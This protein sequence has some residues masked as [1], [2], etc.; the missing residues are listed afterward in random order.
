MRVEIEFGTDGRAVV[1]AIDLTGDAW[2]DYLHYLAETQ[3]AEAASNRRTKNRALR[4]ALA[5][6]F[7]H[8]D[9][10]V[11]GLHDRL[12][13]KNEFAP[14]KPP[15]GRYCTLKN[16]I[17]DIRRYTI[18]RLRIRLPV[19]DLKLKPLRD[20]L[21]HPGVTKLATDRATGIPGE[22]SEADLYSLTAK[23]ID[24]CGQQ[25]DRWLSQVC[26][27]HNIDRF[28]DTKRICKEWA[29]NLGTM[30]HE[31]QEL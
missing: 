23:D 28:H 16:K 1:K 13:R 15:S 22:L 2:R 24:A 30:E 21:M 18:Q 17:D 9:G 19:L 6:L 20:V 31:P 12:R 29:E 5:N 8:L 11:T 4:S 14:Y 7:A 10:V 27:A 3:Q 25:I 26:R